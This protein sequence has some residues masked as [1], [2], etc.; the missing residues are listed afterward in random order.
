[1]KSHPG[2]YPKVSFQKAFGIQKAKLE[3]K[4]RRFEGFTWQCVFVVLRK[5]GDSIVYT[6]G[7]SLLPVRVIMF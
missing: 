7:W 3:A 6:F 4:R 1:M 5:R 2:K